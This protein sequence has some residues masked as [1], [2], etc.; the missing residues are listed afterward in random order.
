L[1]EQIY[2]GRFL[3]RPIIFALLFNLIAL[4]ALSALGIGVGILIEKH[5]SYKLYG[6]HCTREIECKP[7]MNFVC[8]F[9]KC[10]C[11]ENTYFISNKIGC[12]IVKFLN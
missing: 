1:P 3:I 11:I 2:S 6:D 4:V 7:K 9:G 8:S 5:N 12:G 10:A